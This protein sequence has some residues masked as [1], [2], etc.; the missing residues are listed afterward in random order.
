MQNHKECMEYIGICVPLPYSICDMTAGEAVLLYLLG[1]I[2][3][4]SSSRQ[5]LGR[6]Y[7]FICWEL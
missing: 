1:I 3:I 7:C 6:D 4:S 5:E 2:E